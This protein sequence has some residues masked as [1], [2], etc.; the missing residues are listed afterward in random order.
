MSWR[1][2]IYRRIKSKPK[3]KM[4]QIIKHVIKLTK[5]KICSF[6]LTHTTRRKT[7]KKNNFITDKLKLK[8]INE[9][10]TENVRERTV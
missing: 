9:N 6:L 1:K 2:L 7:F 4:F 8:T 3:I 5:R 10:Q